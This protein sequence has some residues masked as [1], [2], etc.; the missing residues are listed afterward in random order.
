MQH[1]GDRQ[2]GVQ[3]DVIGEFEW[4][5]RVIQAELD[6][7]I[8]VRRRAEVF[9]QREA[10]FVEQRNQ[11]AIDDEARHIA[12]RNRGLAHAGRQFHRR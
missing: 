2:A 8:D 4:A 7:S 6:A 5:H 10:R 1:L 3:A 9:V 12:R 11:Q